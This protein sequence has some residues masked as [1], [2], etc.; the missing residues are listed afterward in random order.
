MIKVHR[1]QK[2]E[3]EIIELIVEG[4]AKS[5]AVVGR[6]INDIEFPPDCVVMGVLRDNKLLINLQKIKLAH[7]DHLILLLLNKKYI[8]QLEALFQVNLDF[9][10]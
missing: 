9:L 1:L 7:E 10:S 2:K 3:A 5:S 4:T 8:H 6:L